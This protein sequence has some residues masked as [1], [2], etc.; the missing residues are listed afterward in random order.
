MMLEDS[1]VGQGALGTSYQRITTQTPSVQQQD[2]SLAAGKPTPFTEAPGKALG[3]GR[4]EASG[5]GASELAI[6]TISRSD[7]P[8]GHKIEVILLALK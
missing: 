3:P 8:S 6:M 7:S 1:G 5:Y 4:D 2:M